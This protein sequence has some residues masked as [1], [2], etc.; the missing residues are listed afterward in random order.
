[1][2]RKSLAN[3]EKTCSWLGYDRATQTV[4]VLFKRL[5]RLLQYPNIPP[6]VFQAWVNAPK[7]GDYFIQ[8]IFQVYTPPA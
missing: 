7:V 1:L 5:N 8:N 6:S 2:Q 4:L 3:Y